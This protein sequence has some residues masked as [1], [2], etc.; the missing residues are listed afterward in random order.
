MSTG[1]GSG[2]EYYGVD[3]Q[4]KP[5]PLDGLEDWLAFSEQHA[6]RIRVAWDEWRTELEQLIEIST[7]FFGTNAP[8]L[9]CMYETAMFVDGRLIEQ[10]RVETRQEAEKAH[11]AAVEEARRA[12]P[13]PER[14]GE[15]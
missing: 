14:E 10:M 2:V 8:V 11:W 15:E 13:E 1:Q 3:T 9:R 12:Y 7:K 4:G 5:Y 6:N